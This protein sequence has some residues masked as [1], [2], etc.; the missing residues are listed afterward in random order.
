MKDLKYAHLHFKAD[1][2]E[3]YR[4]FLLATDNVGIIT[5][6]R[7]DIEAEYADFVRDKLG[8]DVRIVL[9]GDEEENRF[10]Y[11]MRYF[12]PGMEYQIDDEPIDDKEAAFV[13]RAERKRELK[14]A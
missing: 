3:T 7:N 11:L 13:E 12:F 14:H 4:D 9:H 1:E 6:S 2:A 10:R 5:I 8:R